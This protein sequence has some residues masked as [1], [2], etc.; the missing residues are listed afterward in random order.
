MDDHG[1]H[2]VLTEVALALAMVFFAIMVLALVSVSVPEATSASVQGQPV[3]IALGDAVQSKSELHQESASDALDGA[4]NADLQPP[5]RWIFYYKGQFFD[6]QLN[7][8]DPH[9]VNEVSSAGVSLPRQIAL[10]V[11]RDLSVQQLMAVKQN[12]S[13]PDISI[14]L[15]DERWI[16]RLEEI[17]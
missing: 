9:R 17:K 16:A 10:A 4:G 11:P 8:I 5:M 7:R 6:A 12:I 1:Q 13:S 3:L 15:L 2:Q 14:A